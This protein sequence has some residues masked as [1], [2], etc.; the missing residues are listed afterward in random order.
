MQRGRAGDQSQLEIAFP[1]GTHDQLPRF[2]VYAGATVLSCTGASFIA[3]PGCEPWRPAAALRCRLCA[4]P[5]NSRL[6]LAAAPR[7][8]KEAG[9]APGRAGDGACAR[10]GWRGRNNERAFALR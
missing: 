7:P 9:A 6:R 10:L 1:I 2:R 3:V 5:P 4:A 8:C